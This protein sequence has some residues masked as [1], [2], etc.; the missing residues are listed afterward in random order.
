LS[1]GERKTEPDFGT[2]LVV[3]DDPVMLRTLVRLMEPRCETLLE[4]DCVTAASRELRRSRI[5][6]VLLDVRLGDESGIDVAVLASHQNPAPAVIAISGSADASEGYRLACSGVRAYIPKAELP[7]RLDELA[8]LARSA[9]PLDP[10]L[11][12]QVGVR[13]VGQMQDTVR[14]MMLDQALALEGGSQ[15]RAAKRLGV[16]RQAVQQMMRRRAK[17]E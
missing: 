11:K 6:L 2:V 12:A 15:A 9:P 1:D 4:A 17:G 5:D 3:E 10:M 7:G 16:T 14:D 13:T 8:H